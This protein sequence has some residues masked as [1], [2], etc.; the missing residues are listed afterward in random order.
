M[1]IKGTA[2]T[3]LGY[4]MTIIGGLALFAQPMVSAAQSQQKTIALS[5]KQLEK[6]RLNELNQAARLYTKISFSPQNKRT[7]R[8]DLPLAEAEFQTVITRIR[9]QFQA[10][11]ESGFEA[12][13]DNAF[14]AQILRK[15]MQSVLSAD[16]PE[17]EKAKTIIPAFTATDAFCSGKVKSWLDG[18]IQ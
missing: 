6:I 12:R 3:F 4:G 1:S 2:R 16:Q 18:A 13:L 14:D 10:C 15:T 8:A 17:P 5:P 9:A 11:M 7:M